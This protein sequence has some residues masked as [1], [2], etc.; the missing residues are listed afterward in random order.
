MSFVF[1]YIFFP[2]LR[3]ERKEGQSCASLNHWVESHE[4]RAWLKM[5]DIVRGSDAGEGRGASLARS[6]DIIQWHCGAK[7]G[8]NLAELFITWLFLLIPYTVSYRRKTPSKVNVT[9]FPREV[10]IVII[11]YKHILCILNNVC[12]HCTSLCARI[13]SVDKCLNE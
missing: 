7:V 5:A 6:F 11:Y 9:Y 2:A 10:I 4:T 8:L 13:K 12:T 3:K 1:H